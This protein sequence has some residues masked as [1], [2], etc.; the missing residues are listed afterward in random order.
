MS[1]LINRK[2]SFEEADSDYEPSGLDAHGEKRPQEN[3]YETNKRRRVRHHSNLPPEIETLKEICG[4]ISRLGEHKSLLSSDLVFLSRD[5]ANWIGEGDFKQNFLSFIYANVVEQPER[6]QIVS[7]LVRCC[8]VRNANI[9]EA[10][11]SHFSGKIEETLTKI[12][13]GQLTAARHNGDDNEPGE[14]TRLKLESR[15]LALLA[16]ILTSIDR[17]CSRIVP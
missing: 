17:S 12:Q 11:I 5:I 14:V 16:P 3:D 7:L 9:G 2:R 13:N 6:M 15:F 8:N 10:V 4:G 1:D